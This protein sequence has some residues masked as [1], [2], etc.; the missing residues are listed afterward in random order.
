MCSLTRYHRAFPSFSTTGCRSRSMSTGSAPSAAR[1]TAAKP[2]RVRPSSHETPTDVTPTQAAAACYQPTDPDL[3]ANAA[4]IRAEVEWFQAVLDRRMRM[5]AG[6]TAGLRPNQ[7][8]AT[9]RT[10]RKE[11]PTQTPSRF[12]TFSTGSM[13]ATK[14]ARSSRL[15]STR[16]ENALRETISSKSGSTQ[17]AGKRPMLGG[18]RSIHSTTTS[19]FE[20]PS[21]QR[22]S[23]NR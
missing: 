7:G 2:T 16:K 20:F 1:S 4:C 21:T 23:S 3:A 17:A 12:S 22:R 15:C 14:T 8:L 18:T 11:N 19:S 13:A 10:A 9:A 6:G 5:H